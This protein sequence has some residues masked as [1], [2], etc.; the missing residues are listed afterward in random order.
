MTEINVL[1]VAGEKVGT[2]NK[3][4]VLAHIYGNGNEVSC[5]NTSDVVSALLNDIKEDQIII[6]EEVVEF[7]SDEDTLKALVIQTFYEPK[8]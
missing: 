8:K 1:C 4:I 7:Y 5:R 6:G 3:Q 2:V